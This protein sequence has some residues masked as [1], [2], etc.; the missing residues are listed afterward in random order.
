MHKFFSLVYCCPCNL[1]FFQDNSADLTGY[2]SHCEQPDLNSNQ[3]SSSN[4]RC[5]F[6]YFM[7]LK[8]IGYTVHSIYLGFQNISNKQ[9]KLQKGCVAAKKTKKSHARQLSDNPVSLI[10]TIGFLCFC[11]N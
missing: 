3:I 7:H 4:V 5:L 6:I 11:C 8:N 9:T 10:E 1:S 2:S